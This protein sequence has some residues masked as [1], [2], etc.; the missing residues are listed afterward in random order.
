MQKVPQ[1]V[2]AMKKLYWSL[3]NLTY[4]YIDYARHYYVLACI[5]SAYA[6]TQYKYILS[7]VGGK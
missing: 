2:I 6:E 3:Y 5:H 7:L 1:S 4:V